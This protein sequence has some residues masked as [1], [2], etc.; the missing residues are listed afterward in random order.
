MRPARVPFGCQNRRDGARLARELGGQARGVADAVGA[1]HVAEVKPVVL[2][3]V[4]AQLVG[5]PPQEG[6]KD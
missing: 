1:A 6:R 4:G 2:L 5:E 3:E